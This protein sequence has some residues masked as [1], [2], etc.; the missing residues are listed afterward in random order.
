MFFHTFTVIKTKIWIKVTNLPLI[1]HKS[2]TIR[3]QPILHLM[4][5]KFHLQN[6]TFS[7]TIKPI[8]RKSSLQILLQKP[9]RLR[10][11]EI[12]TALQ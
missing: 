5:L 4:Q 7:K 12:P 6:F 3:H 2:S 11:M 1:I 8:R 9:I 10:S